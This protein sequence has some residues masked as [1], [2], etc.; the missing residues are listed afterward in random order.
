LNIGG[1]LFESLESWQFIATAMTLK[2]PTVL[3]VFQSWTV[4]QIFLRITHCAVL[5]WRILIGFLLI[6]ETLHYCLSIHE[7]GDVELSLVPGRNFWCHWLVILCR[8]AMAFARCGKL[9]VLQLF[10][11]NFRNYHSQ[12]W[13]L[14]LLTVPLSGVSNLRVFWITEFIRTKHMRSDVMGT[15]N[16]ITS[17]D[18]ICRRQCLPS[19]MQV[20]KC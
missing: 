10:A 17:V 1:I 2:I 7:N 19:N 14:I 20:R 5:I 13:L 18:C 3:S 6:I 9:W 12:A 4:L 8:Q 11:I 16:T 15:L